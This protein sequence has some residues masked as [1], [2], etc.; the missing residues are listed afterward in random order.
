MYNPAQSDKVAE[1]FEDRC[2][3]KNK[4][5]RAAQ[6]ELALRPGYGLRGTNIVVRANFFEAVFHGAQ[7]FSH[8]AKI[9][10]EADNARA[11][12]EVFV[13]FMGQRP[14]R[15]ANAATD[16]A[17]EV[18]TT[19]NMVG[20]YEVTVDSNLKPKKFLVILTLNAN[21]AQKPGDL[22]NA[23]DDTSRRVQPTQEDMTLRMMNILMGTH[24]FQDPGATTIRGAGGNK[25][26][27]TDERRRAADPQGGI[28]CIRGF[29]SSARICD[30]RIFIN[31]GVNH[32]SFFHQGPLA[33]IFNLFYQMKGPDLPLLNRYI[34]RLRVDVTHLKKRMVCGV[35]I[36]RQRS[37]WGLADS[38][39][40]GY[41]AKLK[42][43]IDNPPRFTNKDKFG[44][45]PDEVSFFKCD[46]N[47]QGISLT[48]GKYVT[49]TQFF[50]EGMYI[51]LLIAVLYQRD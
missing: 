22:V 49:V 17:Q 25:S 21:G 18:V 41:D 32:S 9:E 1:A 26:F 33:N 42:K 4:G 34:N 10:P 28:E 46:R 24:P 40:D 16:S 39:R 37:I 2:V 35:L 48:T 36:N 13:E 12:K 6:G 5:H 45:T 47:A 19:K 50:K 8:H 20:K 3:A 51:I 15:D 7:W 27:W 11:R 29:S 30:N 14:L 38:S 43:R 44:A 31:L 23:L